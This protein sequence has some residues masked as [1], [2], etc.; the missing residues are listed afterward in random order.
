MAAKDIRRNMDT[1]DWLLTGNHVSFGN[2]TNQHQEDL[3]LARPGDCKSA[4]SN[5][6]G[7]EDYLDDDNPDDLHASIRRKFAADGM[8][9][10]KVSVNNGNIDIDAEYNNG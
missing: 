3:L 5:T 6:V 10:N 7:L 1:K 8:D 4:I 2:A 9:V